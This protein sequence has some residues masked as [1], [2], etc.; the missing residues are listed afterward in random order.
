VVGKKGLDRIAE[1]IGCM[2]PFVSDIDLAW[3]Y[4]VSNLLP[5]DDTVVVSYQM[6]LQDLHCEGQVVMRTWISCD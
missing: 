1:L 3:P 2:V 4:P 6:L 5:R